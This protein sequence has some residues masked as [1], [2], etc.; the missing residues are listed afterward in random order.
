LHS[1]PTPSTVRQI[2]TPGTNAAL[3][4]GESMRQL[5]PKLPITFEENHGQTNKDVR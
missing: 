4:T 2:V 3:S 5:F 1:I